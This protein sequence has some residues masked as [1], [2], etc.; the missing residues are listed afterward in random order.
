MASTY[1][2]RLTLPHTGEQAVRGISTARQ[3][4]RLALGV[5]LTDALCLDFALAVTRLAH[6]G[7]GG[8]G[9]K[10]ALLLLLAP[11]FWVAIFAALQLYS[12]PRLSP[13]T[14]F[15]RVLEAS[16]LAV[17]LSTVL[18][19]SPGAGILGS[20]SRGWMAM[21][22]AIALTLTLVTRSQWHNLMG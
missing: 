4:R 2:E 16:A 17:A 19:A 15:R 5:A 14:E 11:L 7:L 20:L 6:R 18:L 1:Q 21:V 13:A 22:W 12:L 8:V 10:F 3:Y 9:P